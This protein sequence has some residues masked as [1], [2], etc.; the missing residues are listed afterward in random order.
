MNLINVQIILTF[1]YLNAIRFAQSKQQSLMKLKG[2]NLIKKSFQQNLNF[3]SNNK[4]DLEIYS[5]ALCPDCQQFILGP[6]QKAL[7]DDIILDYL[8]IKIYFYGN[9][10]EVFDPQTKL[11]S[12]R[13]QHGPK[14]CEGNRISNCI[15]NKINSIKKALELIICVEEE[16][17]RYAQIQM[18]NY[19][20]IL[21]KCYQK[22]K[23]SAQDLKKIVKCNSG[24]EGNI[25][26]H[27][28][29]QKTESQTELQFVPWIL[30]DGKYEVQQY[31]SITKDLV[32][33][34][35]DYYKQNRS[36][37]LPFCQQNKESI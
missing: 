33:F 30:V 28:A 4:L 7:N 10:E 37:N 25:L 29:A 36:V 5:E 32:I 8:N 31:N 2:Q 26:Q 13:C 18:V 35:C 14:E 19:D 3:S 21:N 11:F 24:E 16:I 27:L 9:A 34:V 20:K 22:K 23:I 15:M 6:L 12:Y 1:I 17:K